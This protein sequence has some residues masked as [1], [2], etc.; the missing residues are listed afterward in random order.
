MNRALPLVA[1]ALALAGCEPP[2]PGPDQG[3]AV[4]LPAAPPPSQSDRPAPPPPAP[5]PATRV[6]QADKTQPDKTQ[7]DL[8]AV[9]KALADIQKRLDRLE[10]RGAPPQPARSG[11]REGE[12]LAPPA[13]SK[14]TSPPPFR[15]VSAEADRL[16]RRFF[17]RTDSPALHE[18][19]RDQRLFFYDLDSTPRAYQVFDEGDASGVR[20]VRPG[21]LTA[22]NEFPWAR[23]AGTTMQGPVRSVRFLRLAGPVLWWRQRHS[24]GSLGGFAWEFPPGTTVGE[25]L[26]LED[27]S[28]RDH[29]WELR[30]RTKADDGHWRMQAYRPFPTED[31]LDRALTRRGV[32][33]SPRPSD[34]RRLDSG[35]QQDAFRASGWETVVQDLDPAVVADLLD[36]T[37][38]RPAAGKSWRSQPEFGVDV[39]APTSA[40]DFSVVPRGFLGA[41]LP[42][43]NSDCMRCH[44]DAGRVV[45]LPGEARWRVRGSDGIFSW[46]PWEAD[47]LRQGALRLNEKLVSAGLVRHKDGE[48]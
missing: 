39:P 42:V 32:A 28:G 34:R 15:L 10:G 8:D 18:L 16:Y 7:P 29:A 6:A 47:S 3:A 40:Q 24:D 5:A 37:P 4:S 13:G 12:P 48:P 36:G 26:L 20:L 14:A 27:P 41:F 11:E 23:P 21:A 38:F 2:V 30:T 17:P 1:V 31:D 9:L 43:S 45:N 33:F 19:L 25:V 22:N 44:R 35:H 46:H